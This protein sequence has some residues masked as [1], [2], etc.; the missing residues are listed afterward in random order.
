MCVYV[1]ERPESSALLGG[2]TQPERPAH[3]QRVLC[4]RQSRR[5]M[6]YLPQRVARSADR[7]ATDRDVVLW[8]QASM[9]RAGGGAE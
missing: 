4:G 1:W 7:T 8:A 2:H 6:A 5:A 3:V 9:V